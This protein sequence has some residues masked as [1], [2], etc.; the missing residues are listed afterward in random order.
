MQERLLILS[1]SP[2]ARD[3]RVLRQ[4]SSLIKRYT[5]TVAGFGPAPPHDVEFVT[6]DDSKTVLDKSI[7]G[8]R[9]VTRFFARAYWSQRAVQQALAALRGRSFDLIIANDISALP[10]AERLACGKAGLL[11]DAHEYSPREGEDSLVWNV[12]FRRYVRHLCREYVPRVDAMTT[13]CPDIAEEYERHY[14]P[15]GLIV[16]NA[17]HFAEIAPRPTD[18]RRIRIIHH[19]YCQPARRIEDMIT[20]ADHLDERFS[21]TLMLMPSGQRYYER[22]K[23]RAQ[24]SRNV[25]FREPVPTP[26]IVP[27]L[28]EY[29]IGLFLLPMA[30]FNARYALPNKLFEFIQARLA[31]AIGPSPAMARIV[32]EHGVGMVAANNTPEALASALNAASLKDI[33]AWKAASDK[34]A[35]PLSFESSEAVLLRAV[36]RALANKRS[37]LRA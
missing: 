10:L 37:A 9:L 24:N 18:A 32:R 33:D 16:H 25:C 26:A 31:V 13:V 19:G 20:L 21:L 22:V 6:L 7:M 27:A 17:P 29:D 28:S 4:L 2:I 5:I 1:L 11:L 23:R 15:R 3:P 14:G 35:R 12:L 34:A 8:L 30:N 36:D